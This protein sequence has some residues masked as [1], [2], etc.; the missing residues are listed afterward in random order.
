MVSGFKHFTDY[1]CFHFCRREISYQGRNVQTGICECKPDAMAQVGGDTRL[2][3][4][5]QLF[6]VRLCIMLYLLLFH[7]LVRPSICLPGAI[8]P[9]MKN[10]LQVL[11]YENWWKKEL[12]NLKPYKIPA[13]NED[14]INKMEMQLEDSANRIAN[15]RGNA[16]NIITHLKRLIDVQKQEHVFPFSWNMKMYRFPPKKGQ[17]SFDFSP[18]QLAIIEQVH[19]DNAQKRVHNLDPCVIV[20]HVP[21]LETFN[22]VIIKCA[23]NTQTPFFVAEVVSN[24]PGDNTVTVQWWAPNAISSKKGGKYHNMA[25]EAQPIKNRIANRQRGAPQWHLKPHF[26]KLTWNRRLPAEVQR[27][28]RALSLISRHIKIKRL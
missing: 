21:R 15:T 25:F 18:A 3:P 17:K 24:N 8:I 23:N 6:L 4:G 9:I 16:E 12:N 11:D 26:S 14:I 10:P 27:K 20:S 2:R 7:K 28:L 19:L 13:V 22:F 5:F 1:R